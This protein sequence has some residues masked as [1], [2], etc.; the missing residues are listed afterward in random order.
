[1]V[2]GQPVPVPVHFANFLSFNNGNYNASWTY[3]SG[4]DILHF[5]VEVRATGLD[6]IGCCNSSPEQYDWI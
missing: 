5:M 2:P 4:T 1:M 3:N 6:W